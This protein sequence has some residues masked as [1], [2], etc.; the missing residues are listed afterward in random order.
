[1]QAMKL[2]QH[3]WLSRMESRLE[4]ECYELGIRVCFAV[5][6][7]TDS[8]G[9]GSAQGCGAALQGGFE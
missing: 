8:L 1:M 7:A 9:I 5:N 6:W 4:L 2:Y 3:R